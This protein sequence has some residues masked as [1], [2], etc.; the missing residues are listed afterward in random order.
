VVTPISPTDWK[1]IFDGESVTI[2]PSIGNWSLACKSHYWIDRNNVIWARQWSS[3]EI[4]ISRYDD[5]IVK[6]KY[7]KIEANHKSKRVVN[8]EKKP[9]R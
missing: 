1:L 2:L 9:K 7:F 5:T 6:Q 3:K 8:K 4:E